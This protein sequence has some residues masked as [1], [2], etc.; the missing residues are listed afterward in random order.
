MS[1]IK[2]VDFAK[3][4]EDGRVLSKNLLR[5]KG[6]DADDNRNLHYYINKFSVLPNKPT[7]EEF[8]LDSYFTKFREDFNNDPLRTANGG[9]YL[10]CAYFII[11]AKYDTSY[12][13]N[14]LLTN[15]ASS[16]P[17]YIKTSDGQEFNVTSQAAFTITWD[18][19]KDVDI[20]DDGTII[21]WIK[22]YTN[23]LVKTPIGFYED[24]STASISPLLYMIWDLSEDIKGGSSTG[25]NVG[26]TFTAPLRAVVYGKNCIT[27]SYLGLYSN[28]N[29]EYVEFEAS[30]LTARRSSGILSNL[31]IL[32]ILKF[33]NIILDD[34]SSILGGDNYALKELDLTNV[35]TEKVKDESILGNLLALETLVLPE[36]YSK[37]AARFNNLKT[38]N[39]N[40]WISPTTSLTSIYAPLLENLVVGADWNYSLHITLNNLTKQSVIGIFNN[41]KD[42]TGETSKKLTLSSVL[43]LQLTDEEL[44]IATNKNWTISFA[45]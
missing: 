16:R 4:V 39:L 21:R 27:C 15:A 37:L 10:G 29:L 12:I 31:P 24:N 43:Q 8:V 25:K 35:F 38:L 36:T 34:S 30:Q 44:A 7:P 17:I 32:K 23:N 6:V 14:T 42:L 3:Y 19:T 22:C 45:S 28:N 5:A 11:A 13:A 26:S 1:K 20:L 2:A 18:K 40:T 9:E 41:L 33:N